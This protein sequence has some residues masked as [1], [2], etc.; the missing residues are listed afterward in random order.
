M[1]LAELV[2]VSARLAAT[3]ARNEKIAC[4]VDLLRRLDP[5]EIPIG[6]AYLSG[7]LRQG[8]IGLGWSAMAAAADDRPEPPPAQASLFDAEPA[9]EGPLH[10]AEVDETFERISRVSGGGS[11]TSRT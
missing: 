10:L 1:L 11:Q 8:R 7:H 4:V 2:N 9:A 3:P 6:V 5:N